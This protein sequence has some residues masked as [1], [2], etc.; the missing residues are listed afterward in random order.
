MVVNK[1]KQ[2]NRELLTV[3]EAHRIRKKVTFYTHP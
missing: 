3:K 2:E 1:D